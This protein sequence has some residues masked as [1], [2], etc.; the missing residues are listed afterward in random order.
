[1]DKTIIHCDCNSFFIS[2]ELLCYPEY[3]EKPVAVCGDPENRHGIVLAKNEVAKK[4]GI[5]TAETLSAAK[6]KCKKLIVLDAGHGKY[7]YYSQRLNAIYRKYTNRIEPF[8]IDE[9]WLDVTARAKVMSGREI[10]DAIRRDVRTELGL[11]I[12]AGVSFNKVFAK[13]GS[14]YKKPD[15]TTV[16][17]RSNFKDMIA[18]IS[19][20]DLLFVGRRTRAL[21][22]KL[23]IRTIGQLEGYERAMLSALMG[24]QGEMLYDYANGNCNDSVALLPEEQKSLGNGMTFKRDLVS[25]QDILTGVRTLAEIVS[26]RMRRQGVK[27]GALQVMVRDRR[28][29]TSMRQ[30]RL[31]FPINSIE[32]I[33]AA[34]MELIIN[35]GYIEGDAV[36][37]ISITGMELTDYKTR[38]QLSVFDYEKTQTAVRLEDTL[39]DVREKFG[40]FSIIPANTVGNSIGVEERFGRNEE[41]P[42]AFGV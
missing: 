3:R 37:A 15:A 7:R 2:V 34:A 33:T 38:S 5:K 13:L 35:G 24:K 18:E 32:E 17:D 29:G 6:E 28:M 23:N 27:C 8:G 39:D 10:A 12:S 30:C 42:V 20:G 26:R 36:R 25:F 31:A 19:V 1:M 11:T 40:F 41:L 16:I 21:L 4:Y 14:D 22:N 9:S